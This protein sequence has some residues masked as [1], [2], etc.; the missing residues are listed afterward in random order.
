MANILSQEEVDALLGGLQ[1]EDSSAG[2]SAPDLSLAVSPGQASSSKV[3]VYDFRRPNRVSKDQ[4][5]FIQ[6]IHDGFARDYAGSL[7]GYL[8]QM[9]DL[10]IISVDQLTYGEYVLSLPGTTSLFIFGLPPLEGQGVIEVHPALIL[11]M[12][13]RLFGGAGLAADY[14]RDLTNIEVAVMTKLVQRALL[15]LAISW[16]HIVALEPALQGLEKNPQMMQLLPNSETVILISIELRMGKQN[17]ILS[18]CYPFLTLEPILPSI[19]TRSAFLG[20]KK[21]T[22]EEGPR[23]ITARVSDSALPVVVELGTT[24]L[25]VGEFIKLRVGDVMKLGRRVDEPVDLL[26]GGLHKAT[27]R[28][29]LRGRQRV[30]KIEEMMQEGEIAHVA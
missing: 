21:K 6:T 26:V 14:T 27:V 11:T 19:A 23:W 20:R 10:E 3:T 2:S 12:I 18:L 8:R 25:T 22:V 17:G 16:E 1:P 13:D 4:L 7:S 5:R 9:V 30:V 15:S 24:E 29:G 28:A